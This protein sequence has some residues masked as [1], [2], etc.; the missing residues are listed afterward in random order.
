LAEDD[1]VTEAKLRA[2]FGLPAYNHASR[3]PEALE[4]LLLQTYRGFRIIVSD[5]GSE[6]ET[7]SIIAAYAAKDSRLIY[8]RTEQR[9][10]Y[11]GNARRCFELAREMFPKAEFFAWAS[12]HDIWHPAW[13][14]R[15]LEVFDAK[16]GAVVVCPRSYRMEADG[17]IVKSLDA[18]LDTVGVTPVLRRFVKTFNGI[19]AGNM[20]YGLY[21][22]DVL[23]KA[24]IMRWHLLPDRLLLAE[25][26]LFGGMAVVPEHLW[27]RR[28]RKIASIDRQIAASFLGKKP[29]HLRVPWYLSH[30]VTLWKDYGRGR[31]PYSPIT[32]GEGRRMAIYY[33]IL[34]LRLV[35]TRWWMRMNRRLV[36]PVTRRFKKLWIASARAI[37]SLP[38]R[39]HRILK[40]FYVR[41]GARKSAG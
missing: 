14:Q 3:L 22:A 34:G 10:G 27:F 24:G 7:A 37:A 26:S 18:D 40:P 23:E 4:S 32:R 11:I 36:R 16:P 29:F 5:D 12:D 38:G 39:P 33:G 9:L 21:R 20:V 13:L 41:F 30:P 25:M 6:D 15:H 17:S 1:G 8:R 35:Q 28:Y 2:V 19:S 31:N